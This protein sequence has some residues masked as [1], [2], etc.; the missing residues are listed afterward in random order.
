MAMYWHFEE[1][2][3]TNFSDKKKKVKKKITV[4]VKI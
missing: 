1:V 2:N 4:T 3:H